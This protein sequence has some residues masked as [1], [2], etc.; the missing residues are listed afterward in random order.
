MLGGEHHPSGCL[1]LWEFSYAPPVESSGTMF[2]VEVDDS[3]RT[4][5]VTASGEVDVASAPR[6]SEALVGAIDSGRGVALDLSAVSFMDS[7]GLRTVVVANQAALDAST[8]FA[9]VAVSPVIRRLFAVT[10]L[11]ELMTSG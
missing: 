6:L 11:S 7:S 1:D 9:V 3:D 4:V 10:G 2:S 5:R 8:E